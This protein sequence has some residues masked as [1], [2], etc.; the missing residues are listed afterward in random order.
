MADK[1]TATAATANNDGPAV[2]PWDYEHIDPERYAQRPIRNT[3]KVETDDG[4]IC[5]PLPIDAIWADVERRTRGQVYLIAGRLYGWVAERRL[6]PIDK[7]P[8]LE[9]WLAVVSGL[10]LEWSRRKGVSLGA[11]LRYIRTK[12]PERD[13]V[14]RHVRVPTPDGRRVI[15]M[16]DREI[17]TTE[18]SG[19][20]DELLD[21]FAFQTD[22]DRAKAKALFLTVMWNRR[23][24]APCFSV[25]GR[26]QGIGKTTLIDMLA[27]VYAQTLVPFSVE[28]LEG[29]VSSSIEDRLF[30]DTTQ[31]SDIWVCDNLSGHLDSRAFCARITQRVFVGKALYRSTTARVND[32]TWA[33]TSNGFTA[34]REVAR[35]MCRIEL[36]EPR[37]SNG[38]RQQTESFIDENRDSLL[39]DVYA[40]LNRGARF[41]DVATEQF[42]DRWSQEVLANACATKEEYT[43]VLDTMKHERGEVDVTA[44][45]EASLR[46]V[47]DSICAAAFADAATPHMVHIAADVVDDALLARGG[48]R[49]SRRGRLAELYATPAF[50]AVSLL[51][52]ASVFPSNGEGKRTGIFYRFR[53]ATI[54]DYERDHGVTCIAP[55]PGHTPPFRKGRVA[56]SREVESRLRAGEVAGA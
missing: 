31:D 44:D 35:R 22:A 46:D 12:A 34:S 25:E 4:S 6:M 27:R 9:C 19:K 39:G 33:L 29:R 18:I 11:F 15:F 55:S 17:D 10:P 43:A 45:E 7:E 50:R 21:L 23:G 40:L 52:E 1:K 32:I 42:F 48:R 26:R 8:D 3:R 5:Q 28:E 2:P 38:W 53:G 24:E 16:P 47:L 30:S 51:G 14:V 20:L 49:G 13:G 54:A 56:T 41:T 36:A 37:Q